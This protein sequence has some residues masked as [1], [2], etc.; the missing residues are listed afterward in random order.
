M[1]VE[2]FNVRQTPLKDEDIRSIV[3]IECHPEVRKWLTEYVDENV[4][5]EFKSYKKFFR[6][7]PRNKEVEVLVAKF[8]GQVIGFLALWRLGRYM[9]HVAS[10]GVSVHPD[11]WGKG[12]ATCLAKSAIDLAREKGFKRLE[13]ETLAENRGMREVAEKLGFRLEGIRK[14]RIQKD[15]VYHDE[16][17]YSLLL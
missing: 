8:N 13:I 17:L 6:N 9:E 11:Y 3:E 12:V 4:E 15:G 2:V 7:L 5:N 14:N 16:V 1:G 10:I